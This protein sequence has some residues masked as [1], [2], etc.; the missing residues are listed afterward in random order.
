[1]TD[2]FT[3]MQR[4]KAAYARQVAA[5]DAVEGETAHQRLRYTSPDGLV[6]VV[7]DGNAIIQ[8]LFIAPG[9]LHGSHPQLLADSLRTA[10]NAARQAAHVRRGALIDKKLE[11]LG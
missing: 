9:T 7:V 1:V 8:E 11:Q 2:F 6:T 4:A 3:E 5:A 10:L